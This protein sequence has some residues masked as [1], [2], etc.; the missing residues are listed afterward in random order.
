M[1]LVMVGTYV[2]P[3]LGAGPS[4]LLFGSLLGVAVTELMTLLVLSGGDAWDDRHR[5]A[6]VAGFLVFF[7][8]TRFVQDIEAFAG[9]SIASVV[10][11][12]ML[13]RLWRRVGASTGGSAPC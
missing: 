12:W 6:M 5:L 8:L 4:P 10:T 9:R 11:V 1:T 13:V 7:V 2:M 3:E